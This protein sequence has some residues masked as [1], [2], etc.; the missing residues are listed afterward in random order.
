MVEININTEVYN[1]LKSFSGSFSAN[2]HTCV[3]W[4]IGFYTGTSSAPVIV[5]CIRGLAAPQDPSVA[6]PDL[7]QDL[8]HIFS[9]IPGGLQV[10]GLYLF[11]DKAIGG[12]A[13]ALEG[14]MKQ[15]TKPISSILSFG[16]KNSNSNSNGGRH[17]ILSTAKKSLQMPEFDD[18]LFFSTE[19]KR[20]KE[21]VLSQISPEAIHTQAT[22]ELATKLKESFSLVRVNIDIDLSIVFADGE[23]KERLLETATP[24]LDTIKNG[25][26]VLSVKPD[27]T[28]VSLDS[29][30]PFPKNNGAEWQDS[31]VLLS[32]SP[33]PAAQEKNAVAKL[34]VSQS[35]GPFRQ[36]HTSTTVSTLCYLAPEDDPSHSLSLLSHLLFFQTS[37]AI[38]L[39][40]S[41]PNV[42][43]T[44]FHF[45]PPKFP[46]PITLLYPTDKTI[47]QENDEYLSP[48]RTLSHRQLLL[49]MHSPLLR[50]FNKLHFDPSSPSIPSPPPNPLENDPR[51]KDVHKLLEQDEGTATGGTK[52][53]VQGSYLYYHYQQDMND[54]GWGCAYRSLQTLCSWMVLQGFSAK[55]IPSHHDIQRILVE[56]G[57]KEKK[58]IGSTEWIGSQEVFLCLDHL[59]GVSAKILNVS[60]GAEIAQRGE[61]LSRHF[62]TE[63]T[64]VMIG[65]GVLAYTLLGVDYNATTGAI[66]FLILD[67]HYVGP[68]NLKNIK[69]KW[70]AW[71]EGSIFKK[72]AHYNLCMPLRPKKV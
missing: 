66:K 64:P 70:C 42:S 9:I 16:A 17:I 1:S 35:K 5:S 33:P 12:E 45:L 36:S 46:H 11:A 68:E 31:N 47:S 38:H 27:N 10:V 48:V 13:K 44:T 2:V 51:L 37:K 7:S 72:D 24:F 53:L 67:P 15:Q 3:V 49:P 25:R 18:V 6:L 43:P 30:K 34:S 57:D 20:M 4:F 41:G 19:Y 8:F 26:F 55:P 22:A 50:Y 65:G 28:I 23:Y 54:N 71:K 59:Y 32:L 69:D 58:F 56:L 60:S 62:K 40:S 14:L 63:G 39:M 21:P 61:E 52:Y 29:P